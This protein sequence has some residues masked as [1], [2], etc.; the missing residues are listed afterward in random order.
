[1]HYPRLVL[2]PTRAFLGA[3]TGPAPKYQP[4]IDNTLT[5]KRIGKAPMHTAQ[6][7][8]VDT[9]SKSLQLRAVFTVSPHNDSYAEYLH[10]SLRNDLLAHTRKL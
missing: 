9:A 6:F 8:A 2:V 4:S 3:C 7:S 10:E 5:L 1:M